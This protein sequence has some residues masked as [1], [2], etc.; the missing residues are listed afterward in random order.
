MMIIIIIIIIII[1]MSRHLIL[2]GFFGSEE[3][4]YSDRER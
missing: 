3:T 2:H 4:W 1:I